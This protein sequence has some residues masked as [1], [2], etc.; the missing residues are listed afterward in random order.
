M[1]DSR[2]AILD[3]L[4]KAYQIEVDGYTFYA[5]AGEKASKPAVQ[6]LFDKLACDE[7]EHQGY[8]K[9]IVRGYEQKGV[10]A[11]QVDRRTSALRAVS[12]T[13]FTEEFQRQARGAA[14]EM[15]VLSIGMQLE[16]RAVGYFTQAAN[17]ASDAE[18]RDFYQFM[19]DWEKEHFDALERLYSGVRQ[20]FWAEG[21]FSPF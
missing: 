6:E 12:S 19:A 5:M 18:V 20:D 11:F 4:R 8:L 3:I 9:G 13:I 15:G 21:R 14:F 7:L 17:D 2:E 16:T 10:A 1:S